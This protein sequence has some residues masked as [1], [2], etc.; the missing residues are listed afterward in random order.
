MDAKKDLAHQVRSL[1][2]YL[3]DVN[4]FK[5]AQLQAI[6]AKDCSNL[7]VSLSNINNSCYL[8]SI[9]VAILKGDAKHIFLD[10]EINKYKGMSSKIAEDIKKELTYLSSSNNKKLYCTDLRKL[11]QRYQDEYHKHVFKIER[12]DWIRSQ[13]EPLDFMRFMNIIFKIPD[14]L[15][16]Q[17]ESW[18]STGKKVPLSKMTR[19]G[20][21]KTTQTNF[22]TLLDLIGHT[23]INI[24]DYYPKHIEHTEFDKDNEWRPSPV[25]EAFTRRTERTTYL[26]TPFLHIHLNRLTYAGKLDTTVIPRLKMKLKENRKNI[27]L[28]SMIVHHGKGDGGHYTCI[29]ECSGLWYH[30]DDLRKNIQLVG[31]FED[32]LDQKKYLKNSTDLF[33]W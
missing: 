29:Y 7:Q 33:Y 27:Y 28:R 3:T 6:L 31:S 16:V 32:L 15:K 26:S 5:K 20:G 24:S 17:R 2:P 30:Y 18:G 4:A 23:E 8:D 1:L 9:I 22:T 12:I 19:V 11:L 21:V 25:K 10:A 14:L 13:S